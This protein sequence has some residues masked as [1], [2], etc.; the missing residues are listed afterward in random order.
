MF[1]GAREKQS[2]QSLDFRARLLLLLHHLLSEGEEGRV[3]SE[4]ACRHTDTHTHP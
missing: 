3:G 2:R 1:R 4:T